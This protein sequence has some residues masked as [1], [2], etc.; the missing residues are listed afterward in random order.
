MAD[1]DYDKLTPDQSREFREALLQNAHA[2]LEE[3]CWLVTARRFARATALA[4]LGSEELSKLSIFWLHTASA[5]VP[6]ALRRELQKMATNHR[7]KLAVITVFVPKLI[8]VLRAAHGN[9]VEGLTGATL[10]PIFED[11][12][13][14]NVLKQDALYVSFDGTRALTPVERISFDEAREVFTA[15][16]SC[17]SLFEMLDALIDR[18]SDLTAE[19]AR[20]RQRRPPPEQQ[21]A[22]GG[23]TP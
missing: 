12:K 10:P 11:A 9:P 4:I 19:L 6:D 13:R 8:E 20:R 16:V 18:P 2:L 7:R 17:F 14:L 15:F 3:V 21:L 22:S 23:A 1:I 5:P